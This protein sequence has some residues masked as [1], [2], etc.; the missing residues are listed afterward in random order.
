MC[1]YRRNRFDFDN[2]CWAWTV[3]SIWRSQNSIEQVDYSSSEMFDSDYQSIDLV[4]FSFDCEMFALKWICFKTDTMR[5][6]VSI[7]MV[8]AFKSWVL[9]NYNGFLDKTFGTPKENFRIA[10]K[11]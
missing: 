4:I 2:Q 5:I 11:A 8:I 1:W 9:D 6:D 3:W 10:E 7:K